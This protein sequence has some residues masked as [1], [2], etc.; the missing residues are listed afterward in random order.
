MEDGSTLCLAFIAV[1]DSGKRKIV[2]AHL[3]DARA[4]I[5]RS[6]GKSRELTKDHKPSLRSEFDR[7][8]RNFG[9]LSRDNRVDGRLAVARSLGDFEVFGVGREPELNE[10]DIDENDKYLVICCDGVFDVLSNDDVAKIAVNSSS[11]KEA[12]F[13]I[14]NA[15]FGCMSYDNISAIVVDLSK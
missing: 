6:D 8:H 2:T 3:G 10:F 15:A 14:R 11:T 12:A 4:L 7:I 13:K 1:N 5:V 9:Y